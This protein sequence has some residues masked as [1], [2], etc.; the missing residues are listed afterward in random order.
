MDS[1]ALLPSQ[2]MCDSRAN[3][4]EKDKAS[5]FW[6]WSEKSSVQMQCFLIWCSKSPTQSLLKLEALSCSEVVH[7]CTSLV[8]ILALV[9]GYSMPFSEDSAGLG[10]ALAY[11]RPLPKDIELS[12]LLTKKLNRFVHKIPVSKGLVIS[13][14]IGV[15]LKA[16]SMEPEKYLTH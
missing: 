3:S 11:T 9:T 6:S 13:Y 14:M 12:T 2:N 1:W 7:P 5:V 16:I 8:V 15:G 4:L 10:L